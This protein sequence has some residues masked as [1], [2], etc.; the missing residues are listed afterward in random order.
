[1]LTHIQVLPL[2]IDWS[3]ERNRDM[4]LG[5]TY[6]L[7]GGTNNSEDAYDVH[8]AVLA[9]MD[10]ESRCWYRMPL[11][12]TFRPP[13]AEDTLPIFCGLAA[14]PISAS[15]LLAPIFFRIFCRARSA[16]TLW[17]ESSRDSRYIYLSCNPAV[18]YCFISKII[19]QRLSGR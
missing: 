18:A 12:V 13:A 4:F 8:V 19:A 1:M 2:G 10:M 17:C 15:H 7:E 6:M 3:K 5:G 14:A 16:R 11:Q 9:D